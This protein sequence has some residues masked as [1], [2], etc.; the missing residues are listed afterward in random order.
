MYVFSF[1]MSIFA[2]QT[3]HY[4]PTQFVYYS[5]VMYMFH[6]L[7]IRI[8]QPFFST[9]NPFITLLIYLGSIALTMLGKYRNL[10]LLP[11][12]SGISKESFPYISLQEVYHVAHYFCAAMH[13]V[14]YP[15]DF[16]S[17]QYFSSFHFICYLSIVR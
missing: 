12:Q 6:V 8:N 15:K 10:R 17:N 3:I 9:T 7:Q 1:A 16:I 4:N 14:V 2:S 13:L 11:F 5:M